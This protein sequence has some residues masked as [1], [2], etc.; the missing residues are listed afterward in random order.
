[1]AECVNFRLHHFPWVTTFVTSP[2]IPI[3]L[4]GSREDENEES[5]VLGDIEYEHIYIA[6]FIKGTCEN[7]DFC[8]TLK[9]A[10]IKMGCQ[11]CTCMYLNVGK[12]I[13]FSNFLPLVDCVYSH[14]NTRLKILH[15]QRDKNQISINLKWK[16]FYQQYTCTTSQPLCQ[17]F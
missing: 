15:R 4:R 10:V 9:S 8:K 11:T 6:V 14:P 2:T 3:L 13:I 5:G 7:C 17:D 12:I 1:M 16:D